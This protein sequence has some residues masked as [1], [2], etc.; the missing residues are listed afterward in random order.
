MIFVDFS[1][2]KFKSAVYGFSLVEL[3]V[4]I[5][6]LTVLAA[7]AIPLFLNQKK[8]AEGV[9]VR[10]DLRAL[11]S[12]VEVLKLTLTPGGE[13]PKRWGSLYRIPKL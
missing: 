9:S 11:I 13:V 2:R 8:K 10:N 12:E 7:I 4:V 3:L 5:A 1:F 6:I